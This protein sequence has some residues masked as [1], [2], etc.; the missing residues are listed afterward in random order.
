M[1]KTPE[2]FAIALPEQRLV[3]IRDRVASFDWDSFPDVGGWSAGMEK[4]EMRRIATHWLER[5]DWRAQEARLNRRSH[6]RAVIDGINLHF[7]HVRGSGPASRMPV[8]LLHGWP[9]S[10]IE[11][12]DAAERLAW[13]ERFGGKAS[14]GRDVV[15]PSLPGYALSGAPQGPIGPRR[16]AAVFDRLMTEVLGCSRYIAAGADWGSI[17]GAWIGHDHSGQCAGVHFK[18]S[19]I[20]KR[21]IKPESDEERAYFEQVARLSALE[22][23]YQ[24]IQTTRPQTLGYGLADS[25]VGA[26]AWILEKFAAWSDLPRVRGVPDLEA[27]YTLDRL[28]ANVMLYVATDRMVTS[29]WLYYGGREEDSRELDHRV[30]VPTS[31][32]NFRD[33]VFPTP[34]RSMV[35]RSFDI[36]RW[37][38]M[39]K[40]GHFAAW[41]QP[42]LY[43]NDLRAFAATLG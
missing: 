17:I 37:T 5:F 9:S 41:E 42:E 30:V 4:A 13:P 24:A 27:V 7:I 19:S 15:I 34:P 6:F 22:T 38:D 43:S 26:A 3:L 28:L 35:E 23:G 39:P 36:A 32:A 2:P 40:G 11:Y 33:P 31:V 25:P 14:D 8:L 10:F 29:T 12:E 16:I 20:R 18:L 21:S 1:T